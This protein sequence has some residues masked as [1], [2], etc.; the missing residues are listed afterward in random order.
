MDILLIIGLF[1]LAALL[2]PIHEHYNWQ[3][4]FNIS[5]KILFAMRICLFIQVV[6]L[7]M[8]IIKIW[9]NL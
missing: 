8:I 1:P 9:V 4:R 5:R 2:F 6:S 3:Y 7:I